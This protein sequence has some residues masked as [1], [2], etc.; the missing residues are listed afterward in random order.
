MNQKIKSLVFLTMFGFGLIGY[1]S[2][3][4]GFNAEFYIKGKFKNSFGD[5][6][7]YGLT[8]ETK[9]GDYMVYV[10]NCD[11]TPISKLLREIKLGDDLKIG[12]IGLALDS[13]NEKN[14]ECFTNSCLIKKIYEK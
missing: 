6:Q 4:N 12:C 14:L 3:I 2:A 10:V 9:E 13:D 7:A 5:K 11:Q 1:S 8:L